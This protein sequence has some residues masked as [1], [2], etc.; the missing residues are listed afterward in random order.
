MR[1]IE[2]LSQIEKWK[3]RAGFDPGA[4]IDNAVMLDGSA[5][6]NERSGSD[7]ARSSYVA[8]SNQSCTTMHSRTRGDPKSGPHFVAYRMDRSFLHQAVECKGSKLC[9]RAQ[10]IDISCSFELRRQ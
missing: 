10:S 9:R 6:G 5:S 3:Q 7:L 8:R 4:A 2:S 1:K